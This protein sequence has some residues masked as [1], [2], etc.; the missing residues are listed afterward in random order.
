MFR[1]EDLADREG[2]GLLREAGNSR[3]SW[4]TGAHP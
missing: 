1:A 4:S 2:K 3:L